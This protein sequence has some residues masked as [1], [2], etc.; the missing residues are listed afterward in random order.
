MKIP[1]KYVSLQVA[2]FNFLLNFIQKNL[3]FEIFYLLKARM[4]A[5]PIF[6]YV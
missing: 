3:N 4:E 1:C 5:S 6:V 2:W